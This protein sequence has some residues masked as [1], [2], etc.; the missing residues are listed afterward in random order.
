MVEK[1]NIWGDFVKFA[2]SVCTLAGI[3]T[4]YLSNHDSRIIAKVTEQIQ[5]NS[6]KAELRSGFTSVMSFQIRDSIRQAA[7]DKKIDS[8][9]LVISY[10]DIAISQLIDINNNLYQWFINKAATKA[11]VLSIQE[12]FEKNAIDMSDK[13]SMYNTKIERIYGKK[14]K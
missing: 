1:V 8:L 7:T 6:E 2:I 11:D 14:E 10:Q 5:A 3:L 9:I 13:K 4:T 12:M